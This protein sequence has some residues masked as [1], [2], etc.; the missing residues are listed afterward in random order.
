MV[1]LTARAVLVASTV[2]PSPSATLTMC[3]PMLPPA[4]PRF[5]TIIFHPVRSSSFCATMR[6]MTSATPPAAKGT[7]KGM[8]LVG[9]GSVADGCEAVQA[10]RPT[11]RDQSTLRELLMECSV[12][13]KR[14]MQHCKRRDRC[15][16]RTNGAD[17]PRT[18]DYYQSVALYLVLP[19]SALA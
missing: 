7:T 1:A 3:A 8:L 13:S 16:R 6:A 18:R 14:S 15:S 9:Y 11:R 12:R 10:M 5:S 17:Q 19:R 2:Y 4:P